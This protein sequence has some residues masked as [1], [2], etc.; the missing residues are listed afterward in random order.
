MFL[1]E[2]CADISVGTLRTGLDWLK[3]GSNI[4][5]CEHCADISGVIKS[6]NSLKFNYSNLVQ[7]NSEIC[8]VFGSQETS[9]QLYNCMCHTVFTTARLMRLRNHGS[10]LNNLQPYLFKIHFYIVLS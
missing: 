1:C 3:V 8:S 2:H 5:F 6:G 10:P 9:T 4:C 7:Q